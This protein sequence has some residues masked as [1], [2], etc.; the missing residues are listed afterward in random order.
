MRA[1]LDDTMVTE[2]IEIH[3]CIYDCDEEDRGVAIELTK[4]LS[5][6][7]MVGIM[8]SKYGVD[9][10]SGIEYHTFR[11]DMAR[12]S[13]PEAWN[14]ALERIQEASVTGCID[15]RDLAEA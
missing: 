11:Y 1:L 13:I 2:V 8:C 14:D 5:F 4:P 6:Q 9:A 15:L 12:Y 7:E 3:A 10:Y